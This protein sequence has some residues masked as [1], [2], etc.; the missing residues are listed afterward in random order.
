MG[1]DSFASDREP[2]SAVE[3]A[4]AQ[5]RQERRWTSLWKWPEIF[6][7]SGKII[8]V[9]V[10]VIKTG[11]CCKLQ[12]KMLKSHSSL[13]SSVGAQDMRT[14]RRRGQDSSGNAA[15]PILRSS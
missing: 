12:I 1:T 3:T 10:C 2:G 15:A 13:L 5:E 7:F 6:F 14:V 11:F 9:C 8:C 4:L